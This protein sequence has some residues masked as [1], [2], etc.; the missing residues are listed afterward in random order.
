MVILKII[1]TGAG[2]TTSLALDS[3]VFGNNS[4]GKRQQWTVDGAVDAQPLFAPGILI[5][6]ESTNMLLIV[7]SAATLY[8]LNAGDSCA[9]KSLHHCNRNDSGVVQ[10]LPESLPL[11]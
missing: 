10:V 7:T 8:A 1:H 6:G 3:S 2:S 4:F 5:N 9:F 11:E